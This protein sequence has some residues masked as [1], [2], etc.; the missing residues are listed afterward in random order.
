[1]EAE[2]PDGSGLVTLMAEARFL[3]IDDYAP[4]VEARQITLLHVP[5]RAIL[6]QFLASIDTEA[7]ESLRA[8]ARSD[9][10]ALRKL[11]PICVSQSPE[12]L[13]R[14]SAPL[15]FDSHGRLVLNAW[16]PIDKQPGPDSHE[17]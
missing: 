2:E 6:R 17:E 16:H 11:S 7:I 14:V 8:A 5:A 4:D 9:F 1:M 10:G 13:D 3:V 15:G 12:W